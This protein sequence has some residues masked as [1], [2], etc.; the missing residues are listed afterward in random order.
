[1]QSVPSAPQP[2]IGREVGRDDYAL[3]RVPEAARYS[4]WSVAV[5]RFGQL[6]ALSQFLLGATLGFGM[7][8]WEAFWA[9]TLGA[10]ILEIVSILTGIAGQRE[11]LSTT[12]L[13]R[14]T[15]FGR[16]GSAIIGLVVAVSLIGWF[17]VQNAVFA[18]GIHSLIGG[19]PVWAWSIITGMA[20]TLIVIYGFLSMAWTAYITVPAFLLLAGASILSA[21]RE[22]SLAEL[23]ASP[24]PGEPLS[25]AA[26]TTLVAGGFIVGAV[27]TPDMTRF[28]RSP[29]DVVKQTVVGITLGE[30]LIGLIGVLL[31]HAVK[32]ADIIHIVTSTSGVIGTLI[33]ITATLKINDW[34]L[35]SSSL[36]I[37]NILDTVWNKKVNRGLIT[38][39]V[40]VLGTALSALGILDRFVGF[41]TL[42][43][44]T[45]PPLAGIMIV[46][47]FFLRRYRAELEASRARGV[48]PRRVEAWNPIMLITWIAASIIGYKVGRGIPALNALIVSGLL[49]Y[50]LMKLWSAFTSGSQH[51]REV[52]S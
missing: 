39:V 26:G 46:D 32:S 45:I 34:N 9:L 20:V 27:I 52:E 49:Y 48:L 40:G 16:Y 5:Q 11:G 25:L 41:L 28:N 36:G 37:V 15:G 10:V 50:L 6:S 22:H 44:V 33:L 18:Q 31:A 21:L 3:T 23:I 19:L 17:G 47:Y 30:Y 35:Y 12:V 2:E 43:G 24:P 29:W 14:W 7:T 13:G 42:L 8:F 4:W 1:M 51:F 38:V